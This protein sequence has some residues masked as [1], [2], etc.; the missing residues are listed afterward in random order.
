M[1]LKH[2]IYIYALVW[3][4]LLLLLCGRHYVRDA[5]C[6]QEQE[7]V[8]R[9]LAQVAAT[10][11]T[12]TTLMIFHIVFVCDVLVSTPPQCIVASLAEELFMA[13]L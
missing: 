8:L 1:A 7:R 4:D 10:E 11:H 6:M 5:A 12:V 13:M 3:H 9:L 2:P